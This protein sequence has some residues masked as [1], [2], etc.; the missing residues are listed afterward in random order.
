MAKDFGELR[1]KNPEITGVISFDVPVET[2]D[3]FGFNNVTAIKLDAEGAEY[4][5]L[6]G[7]RTLLA[8]QRPI[9]TVELEERHKIGCTYSVPAF[10]DA[11]GYEGFFELDGQM[12]PMS[13]FDRTLMQRG[14][15]SPASHDY[16][17]PY[18]SWFLFSPVL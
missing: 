6:S 16:S 5:V 3:S 9:L 7:G 13:R 2:L 10:L 18:V 8:T 1:L 11:L 17:D 15:A 4:E 12:L 14:S